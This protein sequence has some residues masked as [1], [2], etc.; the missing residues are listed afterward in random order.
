MTDPSEPPEQRWRAVGASVR[1]ASHELTGAPNQDAFGWNGGDGAIEPLVCGVSDGHGSE[2]CFRSDVGSRFAVETV[3]EVLGAMSTLPTPAE[4]QP[5]RRDL[6]ERWR[7]RVFAHIAAKPF[8]GVETLRLGMRYTD[9]Q[10]LLAY[11]ATMLGV[12]VAPEGIL[13]LQLGDGDIII[14]DEDDTTTRVFDKDPN[15]AINETHSLCQ[16]EAWRRMRILTAP[17]E[18]GPA[19]VLVSTDGYSNS[20]RSDAEFFLIGRNY[21]RLLREQ[22]FE[23]LTT[24]LA[25]ILDEAQRLGSHDDITLAL[26]DRFAADPPEAVPET[27]PEEDVQRESVLTRDPAPRRGGSLLAA[28]ALA[29]VTALLALFTFAPTLRQRVAKAAVARA[30]AR[31]AAGDYAGA[32]S[33]SEGSLQLDSRTIAAQR[34]RGAALL[35]LLVTEPPESGTRWSDAVAAWSAALAFPSASALDLAGLGISEFGAGR[36]AEA[37]AALSKAAASDVRWQTLAQE[38]ETSESRAVRDLVAHFEA[39]R[40]A[41]EW[42]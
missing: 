26:I 32:L 36:P 40:A 24:Q 11:G 4:I 42:Q 28:S 30:A 33:L 22:G 1:G 5:L 25:P 35:H 29:L 23:S 31:F 21:R 18:P 14:C 3:L 12:R 2:R 34:I 41:I 9:E 6:V 37:A 7:A 20:F 10:A 13:Y 17:C 38:L 39:V 15:L 16:P 27:V 8:D 19:L